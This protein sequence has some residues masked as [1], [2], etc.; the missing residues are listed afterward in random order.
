MTDS[1]RVVL[2]TRTRTQ[3][4]GNQALSLVWKILASQAFPGRTVSTIE[5]APTLLK[6]YTLSGFTRRADPAAH[7]DNIVRRIV[8][9][10]SDKSAKPLA[11]TDQITLVTGRT[12]NAIT[13]RLK[14]RLR[15]RSRFGFGRLGQKEFSE[16]IALFR[17]A[18]L[19][20]VNPAGEFHSTAEDI[21]LAYLLD[22]RCAQ[23]LGIRTA[24]VNLSFEVTHPVIRTLSVHVFDRC[25]LLSFRDMQ[26]RT[27]YRAAGGKRE[28]L[29]VPDGAV[30]APQERSWSAPS[31][32]ALT[33]NALKIA[34]ANFEIQQKRLL[35]LMISNDM[36]PDLI[37]NEWDSDYPL[38]ARYERT[39]H[40]KLC[41]RGLDSDDYVRLLSGYKAVAS[42]RLHTCILGL[43]AGIPV[44]PLEIG[45]FKLA[46]FFEEIGLSGETVAMSQDA[47]QEH[48]VERLRQIINNREDVVKRQQTAFL[49][50]RERCQRELVEALRT[51]E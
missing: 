18:N 42:S 25:E 21:A 10:L 29:I 16:R 12:H 9:R 1:K 49:A 22:I 50:A 14:S 39:H 32:I 45:T 7:L 24:I 44:V 2:V 43:A 34:A 27:N 17:T 30:L 41:S 3:N 38:L 51:L 40:L 35:D 31:G 19:V 20:I 6:R 5:R 4:Q 47:W 15:L 11:C 36:K 8:M 26:S 28:P 13:S 37:S 23:M 48:A 46:G 33:I